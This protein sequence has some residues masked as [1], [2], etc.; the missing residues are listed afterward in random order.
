MTAKISDK[1]WVGV[2]NEMVLRPKL[3]AGR[4]EARHHA[5]ELA[6]QEP[7]NQRLTRRSIV[8]FGSVTI[9]LFTC[10]SSRRGSSRSSASMPPR[11]TWRSM[12]IERDYF[13]N[14]EP[15]WCVDPK[16]KADAT[17]ARRIGL[18]LEVRKPGRAPT[19]SLRDEAGAL[20]RRDDHASSKSTNFSEAPNIAGAGSVRRAINHRA[21]AFG[22]RLG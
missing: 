12:V 1:V 4:S 6:H 15:V 2:L 11:E 17:D 10:T 3:G 18:H 9:N 19:V 5:N 16:V 22:R 20:I 7:S 13:F 14:G 21:R 8:S